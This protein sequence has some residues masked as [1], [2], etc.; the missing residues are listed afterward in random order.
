MHRPAAGAPCDDGNHCTEGDVC[1]EDGRCGGAPGSCQDIY[2]CTDDACDPAIGCTYTV[3]CD[4]G[5]GCTSDTCY[6]TGCSHVMQTGSPCIPSD[7]CFQEGRIQCVNNQLACV[8]GGLRRDCDSDNDCYVDSCDPAVGCIHTP[9]S[10]D[11]G[12][13][14]TRDTCFSAGG[15]SPDHPLVTGP[16]DD[17]DD[18]TS[19]DVC[20]AA[21]LNHFRAWCRGTSRCDDG[22][23]CTDDLC[24]P[25]APDGCRHVNNTL[26]CSDG[27]VCTEV[28]RCVDGACRPGDP[29]NQNCPDGDP[30]TT[31]ICDPTRGC[32]WASNCD[33]GN[34]CTAD[35]CDQTGCWHTPL[36]GPAC[37]GACAVGSACVDGLCTG[38]TPLSCDDGNVCTRD[39]CESPLGC[40]HD[41]ISC[42]DESACTVD[43]CDPQAG[44]RNDPISCDD[45]SVCT[46]DSCDPATGCRHESALHC[47]DGNACTIDA[48][49]P[50]SG[51][52]SRLD[53]T[54]PDRD[55]DGI[56]DL[57]DDCPGRA[58]AAQSDGDGDGVGDACD[59][60]PTL[61][62]PA[63][64]PSACVQQ[65][66]DLTLDLGAGGPGKGS[67]LV[68][69]RTTHEV[70]LAGF[71]L[72]SIDSRGRRTLLT[73][74]R[75]PCT[76]CST[77]LGAGYSVIL[78][79]HHSG[80]GVYVEMIGTAGE[81]L[82]RFGP[83]VRR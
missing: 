34:P 54:L 9:V 47:D 49:D 27:V 36:S 41:P 11:D 66:I 69:W 59:V 10:C 25:A 3:Q 30:C 52:V 32:I 53:P 75:V 28:D 51:C 40:R 48:C 61:P 39:A 29:R 71:D 12:N 56:P 37:G 81:V 33:D 17:H 80:R 60:C 8:A 21:D 2:P 44:C 15:C 46:A 57:C 50:A 55:G 19:G 78:P 26:L 23:P 1:G 18:C 74:A 5:N 24:D 67:G 6:S 58:D 83:A 20:V 35:G 38:G 76:A 73:P 22:K 79:K 14:C 62:D 72:V 65:V 4:D 64:D 7:R 31:D 16:C 45:G 63:Q 77:G 13:P 43:S 70:T 68:S 82:G 42:D